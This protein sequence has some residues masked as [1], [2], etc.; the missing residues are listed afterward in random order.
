MLLGLV[1][2][3]ASALILN[4]RRSQLS[5]LP[6]R[7]SQHAHGVTLDFGLEHDAAAEVAKRFP[8][9]RG[10]IILQLRRNMI[11]ERIGA[12]HD[13]AVQL[14]TKATPTRSSILRTFWI[15]AKLYRTTA[16]WR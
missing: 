2:W 10:F 16:F 7:R 5:R 3:A 9:H 6:Y 1:G 4:W 11:E 12:N 13:Q 15:R 8:Q 14:G